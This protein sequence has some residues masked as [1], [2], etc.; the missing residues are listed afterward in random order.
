MLTK[1]VLLLAALI[2]L[3]AT[4]CSLNAAISAAGE[5]VSEFHEQYN[6]S[7]YGQMYDDT[8]QAFKD[9]VTREQFAALCASIQT[10][11]GDVVS[12]KRTSFSANSVSGTVSRTTVV[13]VYEVTYEKGT[14]TEEFNWNIIDD[15]AHLMNWTFSLLPA[16]P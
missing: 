14:R 5:A 6:A 3:A 12:S 4:G 8:D 16:S 2:A 13:S 15:R 11:Y 1:S 7:L 9:E 10:E